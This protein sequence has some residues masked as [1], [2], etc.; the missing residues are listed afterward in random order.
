MSKVIRFLLVEDDE[1]HAELIRQSF[2][3][4]RLANRIDHVTN[5]EDALDFLK[6]V[7]RFAESVR[8]HVVLLDL[9][10]PRMSGLDVLERIKDDPKLRQ[11]PVVMLTTSE[12]PADRA[13][14]YEHNA[15]SFVTKPIGFEQLQQVVRQLELYWTICNQPPEVD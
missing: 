12:A 5:G 11:I 6:N 4:E 14:A 10:L 3:L 9:N 1:D 2:S 13:R 8:P 15:N 7:G